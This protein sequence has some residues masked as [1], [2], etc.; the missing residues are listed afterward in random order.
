MHGDHQ[1]RVA[2]AI[3]GGQVQQLAP[4]GGESEIVAQQ[5]LAAT[6]PVRTTSGF[7]ASSSA[8]NHGR[9]VRLLVF[10]ASLGRGDFDVAQP[11]DHQL[12][13]RMADL[14]RAMAPPRAIENILAEVTSAAVELIDGADT[15]GILVVK[16]D[17]GFDSLPRPVRCRTSSTSCR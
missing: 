4:V 16:D 1:V 13:V 5:R 10:C 3:R 7:T 15:A 2:H 6:A 11:T 14:A 9:R 8:S 17:G 12:A